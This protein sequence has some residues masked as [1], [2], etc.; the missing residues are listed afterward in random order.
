MRV[1]KITVTS[2]TLSD[3]LK[4]YQG[5]GV[6]INDL[7]WADCNVGEPGKFVSSPDLPGLLYQYNSNIGY[8][9]TGG[10]PEGYQ[11]GYVDNGAATWSTEQNPCPTGW[12]IPTASE[13]DALVGNNTTKE[14]AWRLPAASGFYR[15]RS[16]GGDS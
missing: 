2:G 1:A 12:R 4:I 10:I 8:P 6:A 5:F 3:I 13:I 11:T 15:S 16:Y 7:R 9:V 14:F